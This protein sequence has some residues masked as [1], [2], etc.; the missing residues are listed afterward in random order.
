MNWSEHKYSKSTRLILIASVIFM[1][2][3]NQLMMNQQ[4]AFAATN[5]SGYSSI[6]VDGVAL[7]ALTGYQRG[8]TA[9][10]EVITSDPDATFRVYFSSIYYSPAPGSN[11]LELNYGEISGAYLGVQVTSA[12]G[13]SISTFAS[14][15]LNAFSRSTS[16]RLTYS[17]NGSMATSDL[18]SNQANRMQQIAL[19]DSQSSVTP[20]ITSLEQGITSADIFRGGV[21]V[22]NNQISGLT[23]GHNFFTLRVTALDTNFITTYS[24]DI[25]RGTPSEDYSGVFSVDGRQVSLMSDATPIQN[26]SILRVPYGTSSIVINGTLN[27]PFALTFGVNGAMTISGLVPGL[28][29]IDVPITSANLA[30]EVTG[31]YVYVAPLDEEI[32]QDASVEL[33]YLQPGIQ[34][35]QVVQAFGHVLFDSGN[36]S[37]GFNIDLQC[38][39]KIEVASCAITWQGWSFWDPSAN[40]GA[41]DYVDAGK[42]LIRTILPDGIISDIHVWALPKLGLI[43]DSYEVELSTHEVA[44]TIESNA[45]NPSELVL[46]PAGTTSVSVVATST[47]PHGTTRVFGSTNLVE[48]YNLILVRH[49]VDGYK[50]DISYLA[51][52]T[53]NPAPAQQPTVVYVPVPVIEYVTSVPQLKNVEK[54]Q[55]V[56]ATIHDGQL[57]VS[58]SMNTVVNVE[59]YELA[60]SF[61][62]STWFSK[63]ESAANKSELQSFEISGFENVKR[64]ALKVRSLSSN[65]QSSWSEELLWEKISILKAQFVTFHTSA[66]HLLKNLTSST[67]SKLISTILKTENW[68][69]KKATFS[70]S[71]YGLSKT[72]LS[73]L[74]NKVKEMSDL[75]RLGEFK[76]TINQSS[77]RVTKTGAL[78][79]VLFGK[80]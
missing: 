53:P 61:D 30:T 5:D 41:G 79:L 31:L 40:S 69:E 71:T 75:L 74:K 22:E 58:V 12:D 7:A 25:F 21:R 64:L 33:T 10:V 8:D 50:E 78:D 45:V 76:L 52:V 63:I 4:T 57:K 59:K 11:S 62:G 32:N 1:L 15:Y 28:Q 38:N 24:L 39:P 47:S 19:V 37:N 35:R 77:K 27:D 20:V 18:Y 54:P 44:V 49:E 72:Q 23:L 67:R 68:I 43:Y 13:T 34:A 51:F 48:G 42:A 46:V 80:S 6:K 3:A 29:W 73:N 14:R 17:N 16:I 60:L 55:K 36:V 9:T 56:S 66:N 26:S 65:S 70:Y 2:L